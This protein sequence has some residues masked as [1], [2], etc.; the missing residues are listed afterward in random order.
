MKKEIIFPLVIGI[1]CGILVM[2]FWQFTAKL[3]NATAALAQL[4]Q[5]TA[6]NTQTINDVV[7]FI[8]QA[9]GANQNAN[10]GAATPAPAA[11]PAE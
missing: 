1:I 7:S 6:Q 4:E 3:N 2:I 10:G 8:N 5:A 11:T 9:T